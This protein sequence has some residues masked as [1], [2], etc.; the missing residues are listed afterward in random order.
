MA[1]ENHILTV[2][3]K[4]DVDS[5]IDWR[6]PVFEPLCISPWQGENKRGVA[7]DGAAPLLLGLWRRAGDIAG[8]RC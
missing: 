2:V 1:R 6:V 4:R 8:G 7:F 3:P 5:H